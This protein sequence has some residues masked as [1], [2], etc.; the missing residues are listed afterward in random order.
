MRAVKR[1]T[2]IAAADVERVFDDP[3]IGRLAKMSRLPQNADLLR[4][5]DGIRQAVLI[6]ARDVG[7]PTPAEIR[8][9]IERLHRAAVRRNYDEVRERLV[10]LTPESR[11]L[12]SD[13]GARP[14]L[15]LTL[16]TPEVL[17]DEGRC[18]A[19]CDVVRRICN[20]GGSYYVVPKKAVP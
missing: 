13:R 1:R 5:G 18:D 16:P 6:Y 20:I 8:D 14:S 11:R 12:L 9:E 10:V 17:A 15:R 2:V 19:A 4:F 7:R 3:C